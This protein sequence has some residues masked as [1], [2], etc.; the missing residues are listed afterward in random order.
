M[1]GNCNFGVLMDVAIATDPQYPV[2]GWLRNPFK[3]CDF[4]LVSLISV[5]Y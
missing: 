2:V 1:G 5:L 3:L 4:P